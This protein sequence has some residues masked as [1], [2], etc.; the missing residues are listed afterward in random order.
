MPSS[1][2]LPLACCSALALPCAAPAVRGRGGAGGRLCYRAWLARG[3]ALVAAACLGSD[4]C[5]LRA[6]CSHKGWASPPPSPTWQQAAPLPGRAWDG[7]IW[8][9]AAGGCWRGAGRHGRRRP[10]GA[11]CGLQGA[12][13]SCRSCP[14]Q[15]ALCGGD[16][17]GE[18]A[19]VAGGGAGGACTARRDGGAEEARGCRQLGGRGQRAAARA[20]WHRGRLGGCRGR[21]AGGGGGGGG[22][23]SP[24]QAAAGRRSAAEG[25]ARAAERARC[26]GGERAHVWG[27]RDGPPRGWLDR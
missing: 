21:Q 19:A 27:R 6:P 12:A 9:P 11:A 26:S 13:A 16:G 23:L 5:D 7:R 15:A 1:S 2:R 8:A 24:A 3:V 22:G 14:G 17:A 4:R 25:A 18:P 20:A 10:C